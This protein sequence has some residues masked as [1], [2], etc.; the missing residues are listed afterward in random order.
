MAT[1]QLEE[2]LSL[3]L[4]FDEKQKLAIEICT[5]RRNRIA[6]VTGSAGTGKTTI[7]QR[8]AEIFKEQCSNVICCAPTGKAARR[9]REATGLNAVTIHKLLEFPKPHERDERTGQALKQGF[10]KRGKNNRLNYAVVL[11]DEYAMVNHEL[12]RQLI[13]ALPNGGLLRCFGDINQLPP[14][15]QYKIKSAGYEVTPFQSHLKM[16]PSVTLDKVYRQGE[17]SGIFLNARGIVR[18]M[19]PTKRDDFHIIFTD[20]PTIRIEEFAWNAPYKYKTIDNQIIV[21]GNKGWIGTYELNQRIQCV[22]NPDPPRSCDPPRHKWQQWQPITIGLNDKVVCTENT[23]DTRDY[24]ERYSAF[25][26]DGT[27]LS[28]S[29]IEPPDNCVM[30]NGEIG[31][32]VDVQMNGATEVVAL[33]INF[34][35]REVVIPYTIHEKNIHNGGIYQTSH[36][37]HL[38]LGYVLTTHKCQGSEFNEI[39]YVL[40]KSSRWSQGRKNLYTAI[41]RARKHVTVVTDSTSLNYSMWKQGD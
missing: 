28:H 31:I 2:C 5:D 29:Y 34:G 25:D 7:I 8:V 21:T 23:Y 26:P 16:F 22:V 33:T 40:N 12:N 13:D 6:S 36:L 19:I 15:E 27:P 4:L 35:D 18:G 9:I 10:P 39:V 32:V 41:T 30:L 11:C 3:E 38:D 37:K 24:F 20:K 17:G 1:P 14:I